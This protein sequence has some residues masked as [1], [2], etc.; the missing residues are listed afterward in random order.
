M[1]LLNDEALDVFIDLLK[2]SSSFDQSALADIRSLDDADIV[3]LLYHN[4]LV[5]AKQKAGVY[6]ISTIAPLIDSAAQAS[7]EG[8]MIKL[9]LEYLRAK[10]DESE[11]FDKIPYLKS[12]D[13]FLNWV[14]ESVSFT[15]P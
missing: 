11:G 8:K 3:Y 4:V 2:T 9:F 5:M 7:G 6:D 13:V 10:A 14:N 15:K 1:R 12:M